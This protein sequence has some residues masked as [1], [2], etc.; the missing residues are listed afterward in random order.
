MTTVKCTSVPFRKNIFAGQDVKLSVEEYRRNLQPTENPRVF[1]A[2]EGYPTWP[3]RIA[4]LAEREKNER[5]TKLQQS[6]G[7]IFVVFFGNRCDSGW[8]LPAEL[9]DF[10]PEHISGLLLTT[11]L[12]KAHSYRQALLEAVKLTSVAGE[13]YPKD[14]ID[15]LEEADVAESVP[16]EKESCQVCQGTILSGGFTYC[17]ECE[18]S[19]I[20]FHCLP[21]QRRERSEPTPDTRWVCKVCSAGFGFPVDTYLPVPPMKAFF[22]T[23]VGYLPP[24]LHISLPRSTVREIPEYKTHPISPSSYIPVISREG[25]QLYH[26]AWDDGDEQ[27]YEEFEFQAGRLLADSLGASSSA[28]SPSK[29]LAL[30]L[31]STDGEENR[32]GRHHASVGSRVA[33]YFHVADD[34][35]DMVEMEEP[36][37]FGC[38]WSNTVQNKKKTKTKTKSTRERKV[39]KGK[40]IVEE[41]ESYQTELESISTSNEV[42]LKSSKKK[43]R[44]TFEDTVCSSS[45]TDIGVAQLS[46]VPFSPSMQ[47]EKRARKPPGRPRKSID[48]YET[49]ASVVDSPSS[50]YTSND[51]SSVDRSPY[52]DEG[53]ILAE[54]AQRTLAALVVCQSE[55]ESLSRG[56][57]HI[58]I[59]DRRTAYRCSIA[60]CVAALNELDF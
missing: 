55:V 12:D 31:P 1:N 41:K 17:G 45:S 60:K 36:P 18:V 3:A 54:M 50:D 14:I 29:L 5:S 27:D 23:V 6:R 2:F 10:T 58:S 9:Y 43:K 7:K 15:M 46:P 34:T 24:S 35:D 53:Q 20:H 51:G 32:W 26:I 57:A 52:K 33:A 40:G 4:S 30:P 16:Q 21:C 13:V 8:V 25:D 37:A 42:D 22:G 59:V 11:K 19:P 44:V 48:R 38:W 39:K 56:R 49:T 28:I 47:P